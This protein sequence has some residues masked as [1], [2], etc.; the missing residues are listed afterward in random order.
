M[1][2]KYLGLPLEREIGYIDTTHD[3]EKDGMKIDVKTSRLHYPLENLK[4]G[5][6]CFVAMTQRL[7][8][9][10]VVV[11]VR[12]SPNSREGYIFGYVPRPELDNF[13]KVKFYNLPVPAYSIPLDSLKDIDRL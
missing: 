10:D 4:S 8:R 5:Y 9:I 2:R 11:F 13:A 6:K 12:L 3:V 1:V 7:Q